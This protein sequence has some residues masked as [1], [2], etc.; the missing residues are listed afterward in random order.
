MRDGKSVTAT[1]R[2]LVGR[3]WNAEQDERREARQRLGEVLA[4]VRR[5]MP[6]EIRG[7]TAK[8]IVNSIFDDNEPDGFAR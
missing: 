4:E 2:A 8:E 6:P 1:L 3:A 7:M 5:N